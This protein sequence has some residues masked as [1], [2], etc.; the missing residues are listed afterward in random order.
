M[1]EYLIRIWRF[2]FHFFYKHIE[3]IERYNKYFLMKH[4]HRINQLK[5]TNPDQ[6][7]PIYK[8]KRGMYIWLTRA[9]RRQQNIRN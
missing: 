2:I 8:D 9:Q 4:A 1:K 6:K 3:E 5:K 7:L